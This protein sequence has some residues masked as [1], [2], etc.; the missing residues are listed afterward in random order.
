[1]SGGSWEA[2]REIR[3][4]VCAE[5]ARQ[6]LFIDLLETRRARAGGL[7]DWCWRWWGGGGGGLFWLVLGRVLGHFSFCRVLSLDY[8]L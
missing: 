3:V 6:C 4:G 2:T 8:S 7:G 5:R 1:M